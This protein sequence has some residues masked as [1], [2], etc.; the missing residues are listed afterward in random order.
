M[1]N[2]F[3]RAYLVAILF[4]E[5]DMDNPEG[6]DTSLHS[7]GYEPEDIAEKSRANLRADAL[8]FF[9]KH[10]RLFRALQRVKNY[11]AEQAGHD[12]YFTPAGHGAGFWDRGLGLVGRYL[13]DACGRREFCCFISDGKVTIE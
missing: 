2:E 6:D 10:R 13:T 4:G 12:Y 8:V 11:S 7:E 9:W 1:F 3:F 5:C